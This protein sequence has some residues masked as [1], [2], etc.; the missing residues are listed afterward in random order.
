MS[1]DTYLRSLLFVSV[2]YI[3][4][5]LFC[6]GVLYRWGYLKRRKL[7]S[8][9]PFD[10][11][12]TQ[13]IKYAFVYLFAAAFF[14]AIFVTVAYAKYTKIYTQISFLGGWYFALSLIIYILGYEIFYYFAHRLLHTNFLYKHVHYV[15][16]LVRSPTVLSIYCFHP[17]ESVAYFMF[18]MAFVMCVPIHPLALMSASLFLHQGNVTG[19]LGYEIFPDKFK[20]RFP[21][22]NS[23][24]GHFFHHQYQSCNYGYTFTVLDK[25]FKTY[26][27]TA[28]PLNQIIEVGQVDEKQ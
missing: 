14:D 8:Q 26:V 13:Q 24:T 9:L 18:H 2:F 19:H 15:H 23:A 12:A 4:T 28:R 11:P 25:I 22:L 5:A 3:G 6:Y 20:A 10:L 7:N 21:L 17:L 16:H 1:L 27:G